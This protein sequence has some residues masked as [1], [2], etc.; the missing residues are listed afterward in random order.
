MHSHRGLFWVRNRHVRQTTTTIIFSYGCPSG[1]WEGWPEL[2]ISVYNNLTFKKHLYSTKTTG[3]CIYLLF[4]LAKTI[5]L[6]TVSLC[7]DSLNLAQLCMIYTYSKHDLMKLSDVT[8]CEVVRCHYTT[9]CSSFQE[10]LYFSDLHYMA[11]CMWTPD[12]SYPHVDYHKTATTKLDAH[13]CI[14]CICLP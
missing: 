1:I 7:E 9:C 11:K 13:N 12:K 6:Q 14:Q 4:K 5:V 8:T 3:K 10:R 2:C